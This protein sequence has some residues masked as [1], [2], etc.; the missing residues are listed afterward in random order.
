M[1]G[2]DR[3]AETAQRTRYDEYQAEV[4]ATGPVN[5]K[6]V[7]VVL[8]TLR[9]P[10]LGITSRWLLVQ[11]HRIADGL[12]PAPD[13]RWL[14]PEQRGALVTSPELNRLP[15]APAELRAWC[16]N[17]VGQRMTYDRLRCGLSVVITVADHTGT[18]SLRAVPVVGPAPETPVRPAAVA[19][20]SP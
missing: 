2:E 19:G 8:A 14:D 20:H 10:Y 15:S 5:G 4:V 18:Y 7:R 3:A 11:A 9:T 13:V 16:A 1:F 12:D 6:C 17:R